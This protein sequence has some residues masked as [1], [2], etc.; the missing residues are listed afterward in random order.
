L[1]NGK[2]V[3]KVTLPKLNYLYYS[4]N[5]CKLYKFQVAYKFRIHFLDFH[6]VL[7]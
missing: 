4:Q 7:A 3:L 5:Y 2:F 6:A 1:N